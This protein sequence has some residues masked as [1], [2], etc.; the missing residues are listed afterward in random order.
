[1]V[2]SFFT[3]IIT[4]DQNGPELGWMHCLLIKVCK[5]SS[6]SL[7]CF[8]GVQCGGHETG[9]DPSS[10]SMALSVHLSGGRVAGI[11]LGNK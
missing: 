6:N 2:P 1:M 11:F 10:S 9:L 5:F 7:T 8:N 4:G 3:T